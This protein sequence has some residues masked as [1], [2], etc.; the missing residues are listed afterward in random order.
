[1]SNPSATGNNASGAGTD[2]Q[3][4]TSSGSQ[5]NT[6]SGSY[7]LQGIDLTRQIGQQVEVSGQ[8]MP[9]STARNGR[10]AATATPGS[11]DQNASMQRVRVMS[12]RMLAAKCGGTQ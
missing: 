11:D 4:S 5:F 10:K 2:A 3:N 7:M 8:L 6:G 12:V 1:A 9:A